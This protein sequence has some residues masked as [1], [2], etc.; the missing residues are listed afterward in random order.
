MI[1][2]VIDT[3][4]L[5]RYLIR[6]SKTIRTL[7]DELWLGGVLQMVSAPELLVELQTVLTRPRIRA[8]VTS[9]D[10]QALLGAVETTAEILP[11]LGEIPAFTRDRKDDVFVACAIAA[12][13][14]YLVTVDADFLALDS[15]SGVQ[16]V[17]PAR[18]LQLMED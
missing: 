6:P 8:Y 1:R 17:T 5:L 9:E 18:L 14:A 7:V 16:I 10:A 11:A 13:A 12:G 4:V 2:I 3:S 15:V